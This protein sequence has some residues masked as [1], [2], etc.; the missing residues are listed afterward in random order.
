MSKLQLRPAQSPASN[1]VQVEMIHGLTRVRIDVE[2]RAIPFLVD[3]KL[4]CQFPGNF[5]KVRKDIVIP[6][7]HVIERRN[8]LSRNDEKV[9]RRLRPYVLECH[10]E[11]ILIDR[12]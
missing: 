6:G 2:N 1:D 10:R 4:H 12:L 9:D 5:K 7:L 3:A 11:L 8:V